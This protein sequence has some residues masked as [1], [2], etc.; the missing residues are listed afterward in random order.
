[1]NNESNQENRFNLED[2]SRKSDAF[3]NRIKGELESK[4]KGKYVALD[5]ESERYWIGDT[6]TE[7]LTKAKKEFPSKLFYFLQIGS[8]ATFN[9]QSIISR[10]CLKPK[11][12]FAW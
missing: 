6:T 12:D 5:F 3:Y 7:A 8:P 2:F 10:S 11:Y 9:I 1:M 4:F